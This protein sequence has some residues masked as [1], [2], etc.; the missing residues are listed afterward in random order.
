MIRLPRLTL[1]QWIPLITLGLILLLWLWLALTLW[2]QYRGYHQESWDLIPRIAR[3]NGLIES[4]QALSESSQRVS[5]ELAGLV[6]SANAD[7]AVT[8]TQL[9][10]HVR[11]ALE[12]AGLSVAGS[13]ILP[14]QVDRLFTRIQLDVSASGSMEAL[15]AGL[16]ALGELRPLVIVDSV[17]LQPLRSRR[18]GDDSQIVNLRLRVTALR[19]VP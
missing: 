16:L 17:N 5:Q 13:Q 7:P 3:L 11:T 8:G 19:S 6:Y 10:Q 15:E 12:G 4:E 14:P 18:R 9:Q 2:G 1:T